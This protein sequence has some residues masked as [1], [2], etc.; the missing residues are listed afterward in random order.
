MRKAFLS[1]FL[2][3]VTFSIL[4]CSNSKELKNLQSENT[5]LKATIEDLK[6]QNEQLQKEIEMYV[7]KKETTKSST[8]ATNQPVELVS[9]KYG[10]D[11]VTYA[12]FTFKNIST[13][14]V[15]AIEFV[16]LNFDNFGR[17]AYYF[18]RKSNGNVS[19]KLNLQQVANPNETSSATWNFYGSD[20]ATKGKVVVHQVHF[21]DGTT[22]VNQ[23]F[24]DIVKKEKESL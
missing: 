14:T 4:G 20:F 13:K 12:E 1:L 24:D 10:S 3:L 21:T 19:S 9:I 2:V 7:P 6:K 23:Q 22:W 18:N 17:P 11:V 16:A 5:N 15:D 8:E